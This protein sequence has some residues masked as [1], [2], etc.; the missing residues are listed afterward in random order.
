[1]LRTKLHILANTRNRRSITVCS[2]LILARSIKRTLNF[3]LDPRYLSNNGKSDVPKPE[4]E[5][6]ASA[7]ESELKGTVN[8]P[9]ENNTPNLETVNLQQP[10]N[11]DTRSLTS[12]QK[13]SITVDL[14]NVESKKF[15]PVKIEHV[16]APSTTISASSIAD[17]SSKISEET[18][19]E[20]TAVNMW[21]SEVM[22]F[23]T[24]LNISPPL[25]YL[26]QKQRR[27]NSRKI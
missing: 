9:R 23:A 14:N 7:S 2:Q 16:I 1:M 3:R 11:S 10:Q 20:G 6:E 25:I 15:Q 4:P 26:L 18:V 8:D 22:K 21:S 19:K 5:S 27:R 13:Q 12:T 24:N 17:E